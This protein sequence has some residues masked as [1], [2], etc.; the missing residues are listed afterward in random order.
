M[1][2]SRGEVSVASM[3]HWNIISSSQ[4]VQWSIQQCLEGG[5]KISCSVLE[6]YRCHFRCFEL[7]KWQQIWICF[8]LLITRFGGGLDILY[9]I[10]FAFKL[11]LFLRAKYIR[12]N[13]F[14][15]TIT[16]SEIGWNTDLSKTTKLTLELSKD[17]TPQEHKKSPTRLDRSL[18]SS[19][20]CF[21]Q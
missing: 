6:N 5:L 10:I 2:W 16:L 9:Y 3:F 15:C 18:P 11:F 12:L 7:V 20:S 14:I 21:P 13:Y 1:L 17:S 19:T 8:H 4:H